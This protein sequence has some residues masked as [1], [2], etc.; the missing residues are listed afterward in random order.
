LAGLG[1]NVERVRNERFG[2]DLLARLP[3][4]GRGRILLTGH[5]DTV[6]PPGTAAERPMT[7]DG[8]VIRGPGTCDMKGGIL[9]GIFAVEALQATGW[10]GAELLSILI[11]SDE[12]IG[13][14]H[15]VPL[16]EREGAAHDVILTLEAARANGDIVSARKGVRWYSV[17]ATGRAAHAGVEPEK[18][19][20]A[21]LA[22]ARLA[23]AAAALNGLRP[24]VTLNLG[25][26]RGGGRLNVV[27]DHALAR[28]EIRGWTIAA[29]DAT[30]AALE[31]L[32]QREWVPG[33]VQRV[34]SEEGSEMPPM[35]RTPGV[36]TLER[37]TQEVAASLGFEVGAAATGG[38]SDIAYC[39]RPG[40]PGLDGLGPI[41]GLDHSPDEYIL[42][43]SIVPRTAL[44]AKLLS[45]LAAG[46]LE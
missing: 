37:L 27:A 14:R 46:A 7:I 33:V 6:F 15:S 41:G 32:A 44:L 11:V 13:E 10:P 23:D 28:Y 40:T 4:S 36:I 30:G 20:S 5:A 34:W 3:G 16:L 42:R 18:G 35:E 9:C 22:I 2:D 8:D 21:T 12:E 39:M 26:L 25:E 43:G 38:A 17:E 29:I 24:G 19:A 1:F 31:A 45:A